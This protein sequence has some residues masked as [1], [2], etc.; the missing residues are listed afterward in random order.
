VIQVYNEDNSS[1]AVEVSRDVSARDICHMFV[2]KNCWVDDPSWTLFE[3]LPHLDIERT[4]ED[5]ESVLEVL[6]GW[7]I[8]SESRLCFKKNNAKYDFFKTPLDFFPYHMVSLS[9]ETNQMNRSQLIQTFLNPSMCP[10]VHGFLHTKEQG[11][12]TWRRFYFVL[13]RSGL[14]F[15]SKGTS[16]G[17]AG[18]TDCGFCLKY[19]MQL[20]QN[21][22]QPHQKQKV[23]PMRSVSES[24]LVAMDFSGQKS[25]VINNPTEEEGLTWRRKSC[26]RLGSAGNLPMSSGFSMA[27]SQP[28]FH[29]QLSRDEAQ[30]LITRRGLEDGVFL[31]RESLSNPNTVVLSLCHLQRVRHFQ[32]RP[33]DD[34]GEMVYSLDDGQTRFSDLVQLVHFHQLNRGVLPCRLRH[35]VSRSSDVSLGD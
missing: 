4:I 18:P 33:V 11:R 1:R 26:Y 30:R 25:R 24:S 9:N 19:G 20:Y 35:P 6:S 28:W 13:R 32:I 23:S 27:L 8:H 3:H 2:L 16:K 22:L 7:G 10:E 5:H 17:P 21:F 14:Y 15:S 12:K 31:L 29:S 34:Q